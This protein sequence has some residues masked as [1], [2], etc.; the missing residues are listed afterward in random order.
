MPGRQLWYIWLVPQPLWHSKSCWNGSLTAKDSQL[1]DD[2]Q[3]L[4]TVCSHKQGSASLVQG[5]A[6]LCKQLRDSLPGNNKYN[7]PSS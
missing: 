7:M 6:G 2:V 5:R 1:A 4:S 3:D